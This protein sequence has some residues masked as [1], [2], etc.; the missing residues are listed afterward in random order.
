MPEDV[1]FKLNVSIPGIEAG[2]DILAQEFNRAGLKTARH[3]QSKIREKARLDTGEERRNTLY[4]VLTRK[5]VTMVSVYNRKIQAFVDETGAIFNGKL[6]PWREGSKLFG[7]VERKGFVEPVLGSQTRA[8]A[9]FVRAE[10]LRSGA[11]REEAKLLGRQTVRDA[12][13]SRKRQLESTSFLIARA[14][15]RRGLPRPGDPLRKPYETTRDQ[16][17]GTVQRFFQFAADTAANRI[18]TEGGASGNPKQ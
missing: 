3:L 5:T 15:A 6:P 13:T 7:W 4:K 11:S 18:N 9:A 12:E 16:E 10:A 1:R 17:R 14:I 2:D 8:I